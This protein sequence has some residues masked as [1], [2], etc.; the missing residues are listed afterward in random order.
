MATITKIELWED[1]G[2]IDGAVEIPSLA[3][4]DPTTP[5]ITITPT[6]P[7][8]PSKDRFF[9]EIK[10]KE[11]YSELLTV[12]YMRVTY[13]LK[14]SLG[15][16]VPHTFW[17]WVDSVEMVSDGSLPNTVIRWHIDEWRTWK[18]AVTFGSGHIKRR[19]FID[20]ASTPI[21][22][23]GYRFLELDDQSQVEL[24]TRKEL[25]IS[26][27]GKGKVWWV[28][29]S[30][31]YTYGGLTLIGYGCS[32][33]WIADARSAKG[34]LVFN[35]LSIKVTGSGTTYSSPTLANIY[36][37]TLDEW[38][39]IPASTI[40][41]IW[42]SP[43]YPVQDDILSGTGTAAD[44][45]V[46][47]TG[48]I[49]TAGQ[50]GY[51]FI[52][53]SGGQ[54][55]TS[56]VTFVDPIISEEKE[57]WV[58]VNSDGGKILD[59]PYGMS[60]SGYES[61]M[62]L[63]PDQLYFTVSF[64]D[65]IPGRAEGCVC[66]VT[67]PTLPINENALTD[68]VFSG[69]REYDREM[70]TLMTNANA[71]K[72]ITSGAGQGAFMGA[73]G[74][75]GA[76]LGVAGGALGGG[77]SYLTETYYQNDREQELLDRLKANQLPSLIMGSYAK[78]TITNGSGPSLYKMVMDTYSY[79]LV[80]DTR[81]QFGISVDE[82]T[83]SCDTLIRTTATTGYYNIQNLIVTGDVPVSAKKWI[84][85]KFRSGVRLI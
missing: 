12:S 42:L 63:E 64:K 31:N 7:I 47:D 55:R 28:V 2:F 75:A 69:Q 78:I 52:S 43:Y 73:F 67:V 1:V 6:D 58:V 83:T 9:S 66:T 4:A 80:D 14:D 33:V 5:D 84:R 46:F 79:D 61:Y 45:L 3:A 59:I 49:I 17:G 65:G 30:Y 38:F 54:C 50:A 53:L 56:S 82:L 48:T 76:I 8:I 19:P 18:S 26:G 11:Y 13:D 21:Q 36:G 44:P 70:R 10:L 37:G 20:L 81:S 60:I 72:S 77:V 25:T 29:F 24:F 34:D 74:T 40:N 27:Y 62:T 35:N 71:I 85:E 57:R 68:Y 51:G 39:N 16:D 22:N 15:V 32:P 23:Y 41:G